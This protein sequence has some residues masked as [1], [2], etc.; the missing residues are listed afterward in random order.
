MTLMTSANQ[1]TQII[2]GSKGPWLT[3][4]AAFISYRGWQIY[5][6]LNIVYLPLKRC[7]PY[8][9]ANNLVCIH[10]YEPSVMYD[11]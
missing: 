2:H 6:M 4:Q 8:S 11:L 1:G 10:P 3:A 9:F 5:N 7:Q